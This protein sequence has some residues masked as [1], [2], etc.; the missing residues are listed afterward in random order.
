M[1][2]DE[3]FVE[4]AGFVE[5]AELL[6][7]AG[8]AHHGLRLERAGGILL[9][10]RLIARGRFLEIVL[11]LEAGRHAHGGLRRQ[12]VAGVLRRETPVG[13]QGFVVAALRVELGGGGSQ[14]HR[15]RRRRRRGR[16]QLLQFLRAAALEKR[17]HRGRGLRGLLAAPRLDAQQH[18]HGHREADQRRPAV[19][20]HPFRELLDVFAFV[21]RH[22]R[23]RFGRLRFVRV[24]RNFVVHGRSILLVVESGAD[25]RRSPPKTQAN[26]CRPPGK[27]ID[28]PRPA[29]RLA[30]LFELEEE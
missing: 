28:F 11:R 2:R 9:G 26:R 27:T 15:R 30:G 22:H 18:H 23:R 4:R 5:L 8:G 29:A 25:S 16:R 24:L 6:E 13:G 1:R 21:R 3:I 10:E 14:R 20:R 17:L 7:A 12:H 19:F